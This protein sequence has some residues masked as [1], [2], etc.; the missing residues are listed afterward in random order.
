MVK[1]A[2]DAEIENITTN[3]KEELHEFKSELK[4]DLAEKITNMDRRFSD[5][6]NVLNNKV[7][8]NGK[9]T[10]NIGDSVARSEEKIDI[11]LKSVDKIGS[12]LIDV[13]LKVTKHLGWH[14]GR[15]D[16]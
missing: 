9:N 8:V 7:S 3:F 2:I 16:N 1:N 13:D 11:L 14:A 5:K 10:P 4:Y 15:G 12:N 6:L